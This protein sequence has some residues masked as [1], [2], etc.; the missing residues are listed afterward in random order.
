VWSCPQ[1]RFLFPYERN[2]LISLLV[3]SLTLA[4]GTFSS[5][6]PILVHRHHHHKP[7]PIVDKRIAIVRP[8]NAKLDRI[9]YCE[10]TGNWHINTGNGFYG[11][12]QFTLQTWWSV[13]GRSRP[14][15]NS[16]LEQKYR[17]VL[18]YKR[19]GS[20]ADWPVCGYR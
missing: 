20:W 16:E 1:L 8:Y 5:T 2:E 19:R 6:K 11:G 12:L 13:G 10:S 7:K 9:A 15:L 18:T 3:A 17:G 14:D 4:L